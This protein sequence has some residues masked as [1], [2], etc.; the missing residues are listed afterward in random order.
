MQTVFAFYDLKGEGISLRRSPDCKVDLSQ[1]AQ[2]FGG[3]GHPAAAGC[4]PAELH[5]LFAQE[6]ARLLS[7][8]F[9]ALAASDAVKDS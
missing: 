5:R 6:I 4:R 2:L 7:G 3:G 9:P 8:A 1:L